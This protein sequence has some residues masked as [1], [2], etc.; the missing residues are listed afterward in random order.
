M[1]KESK[2]SQKYNL[3]MHP[4]VLDKHEPGQSQNS[5]KERNNKD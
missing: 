1:K 4:K 5:Y 2:I 3:M